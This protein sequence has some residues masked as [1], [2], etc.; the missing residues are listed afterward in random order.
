M[1]VLSVGGGGWWFMV[2]DN[3]WIRMA[4]CDDG[5]DVVCG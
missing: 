1:W 3:R 5:L 2:M 4:R